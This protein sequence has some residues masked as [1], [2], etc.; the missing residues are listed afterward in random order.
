M[1]WHLLNQCYVSTDYPNS[2]V[3]IL[4]EVLSSEQLLVQ[5]L[6]S[7]TVSHQTM[8]LVHHLEHSNLTDPIEEFRH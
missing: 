1:K 5:L 7:G 6:V 2:D 8:S 4:E 3:S